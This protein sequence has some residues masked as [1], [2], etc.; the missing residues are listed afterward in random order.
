MIIERQI[1]RDVL[2]LKPQIFNDDRGYFFESYNQSQ[3]YKK[4]GHINFIQDNDSKSSYGV[5]RGIHF[6]KHEIH[7][8]TAKML[9]PSIVELP[10]SDLRDRISLLA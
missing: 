6:Q 10:G 9:K 7:L 3:F 8:N 2:L 5:L 4:I 1:L